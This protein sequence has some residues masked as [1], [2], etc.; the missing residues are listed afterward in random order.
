VLALPKDIQALVET[1]EIAAATAYE[2]SRIPDVA[3]QRQLAGRIRTEQLSR[4]EVAGAI[5]LL[6]H[7][8]RMEEDRRRRQEEK[9]RVREAAR[10]AKQRK[11]DEDRRREREAAAPPR[12]RRR[13][14]TV[15]QWGDLPQGRRH[16]IPASMSRGCTAVN[17]DNKPHCRDM[18]VKAC[19]RIL[20]GD[21]GK[22][23]RLPE[24]RKH[25]SPA[26]E[27]RT[28]DVMDTYRSGGQP[29]R[30][31][32]DPRM[33]PHI[34]EGIGLPAALPRDRRHWIPVTT[35]GVGRLGGMVVRSRQTAAALRRQCARLLADGEAAWE[36]PE[37]EGGSEPAGVYRPA[38]VIG[39][40]SHVGKSPVYYFDPRLLDAEIITKQA[41]LAE[42]ATLM[43]EDLAAPDPA[44]LA[45][46]A[47]LKPPPARRHP[48]Q[49]R[50]GEPDCSSSDRG[51]TGRP[52]IGYV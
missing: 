39:I 14:R 41:V 44:L 37:G 25:G 50:K 17:L 34:R 6:L 3:M 10:Q 1:G 35:E 2:I 46:R 20:S 31:H 11:Q 32:F 48:E 18:L 16:W 21:A 12:R 29:P 42:A 38:D 45:E 4:A 5:R 15:W 26:G 22:T 43:P 52:R 36:L 49:S 9:Q 27:Y 8:I 30:I 47:K 19:E 7:R 23:W 40:Y 13:G 24:D 33:A 51:E 28:A